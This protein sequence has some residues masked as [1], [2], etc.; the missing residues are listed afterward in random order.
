MIKLLDNHYHDEHTARSAWAQGRLDAD[1]AELLLRRSEHL[2][3]DDRLLIELAIGRQYSHRRIASI[4]NAPYGTVGRR[5]K[6]L[7]TLLADPLVGH[8]LEGPCPLDR[9]DRQVAIDYF[10]HRK[11]LRELSARY[12]LSIL[13][14]SQRLQFVRGWFRGAAPNSKTMRT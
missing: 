12:G 13:Y 1:R 8:L 7:I 6:K 14:I 9:T 11:P 5:I 3:A 4:V 10:V 2:A